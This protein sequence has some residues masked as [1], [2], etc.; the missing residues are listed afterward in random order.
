MR[1]SLPN[2]SI[3]FGIGIGLIYTDQ[4]LTIGSDGP[5][6]WAARESLNDIKI[7]EVNKAK[8]Y[9]TEQA[10]LEKRAYGKI[11]GL[12]D[13]NI[14][15]L[16]NSSLF[17]TFDTINKWTMHQKEILLKIISEYGVSNNFK[18]RDIA[19]KYG[20]EESKVSRTLMFSKYR[21]W[22]KI[23]NSITKLVNDQITKGAIK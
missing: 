5:S 22:T 18:Q 20:F 8:T 2:T 13:E 9:G 19:E 12:K 23:A 21:E 3:R 11:S 15:N 16:I 1:L 6:W 14:Q 10:I 4:V 17:F 7:N